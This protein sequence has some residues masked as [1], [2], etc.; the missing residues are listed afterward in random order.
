MKHTKRLLLNLAC[1]DWPWGT[2]CF[3]SLNGKEQK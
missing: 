1:R 2:F 3:P